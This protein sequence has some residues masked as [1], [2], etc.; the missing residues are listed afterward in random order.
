M[1]KPHRHAELIKAWADGTEIQ[2]FSDEGVWVDCGAN[3]PCWNEDNEYRIKPE[4]KK[5]V[6]RWLWSYPNGMISGDLYT[7]DENLDLN[8]ARNIKLE[9]S[10]TEFPE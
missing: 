9:W 1:G 6:V 5:P 7:E 2:F 4:E 8:P 10:R 3:L